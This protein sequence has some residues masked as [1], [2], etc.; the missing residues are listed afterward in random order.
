[1]LDRVAD[2][3]FQ[4]HNTHKRD[5]VPLTE[6]FPEIFPPEKFH[7]SQFLWASGVIK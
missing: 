5:V 3:V 4:L 7:I 6:K 1:M 2:E